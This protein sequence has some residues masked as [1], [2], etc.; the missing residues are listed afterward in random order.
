V[1]GH[2]GWAWV[3]PRSLTA[4]FPGA[5]VSHRGQVWIVQEVDDRRVVMAPTEAHR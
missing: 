5:R 2:R 1:S 3:S 4:A